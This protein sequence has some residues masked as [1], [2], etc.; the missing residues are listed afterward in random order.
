[1]AKERTLD[2]VNELRNLNASVMG[3]NFDL[4]AINTDRNR[5]HGVTDYNSLREAFGLEKRKTF[6]EIF[7]DEEDRLI[8]E[9][10]FISIDNID[11]Y[12]GVL[13]EI[14][15]PGSMFGD[16]GIT[17]AAYQFN[18]IRDGDRFWF[19]HAYPAEVVA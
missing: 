4:F 3:K 14:K 6:D 19:E 16:L 18:R 13:G 7:D 5:D 1:M 10:S 9:K 11:T 8:I 15:L 12:V 2:Y 17:I